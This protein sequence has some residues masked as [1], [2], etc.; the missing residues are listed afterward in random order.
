LL[1]ATNNVKLPD[2]VSKIEM[3]FIH[4]FLYLH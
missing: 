3:I 1:A 4:Q 2:Q